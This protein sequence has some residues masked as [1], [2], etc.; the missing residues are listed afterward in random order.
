MSRLWLMLLLSGC[1]APR[2]NCAPGAPSQVEVRD[3]KGALL[4]AAKAGEKGTIDVCDAASQRLGTIKREGVTATLL[5]RGGAPRLQLRR[6]GPDDIEGA[7][8][9]NLPRLRLHRDGKD[10]HVLEPSG[11][12]M[13]TLTASADKF[14][15]FDRQQVPADS[16]EARGADQ[17]IRDPDGAT[18]YLVQPSASSE[19]AGVFTIAG[20]DRP[21]QLTLYLFLQR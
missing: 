3:G 11:V 7:S 17:A 20:L 9:D 16:I 5:D 19:A 10:L 14:I 18:L 8:G 15:F 1:P 4:V 6:M 13:G 2:S 21:E 12:R